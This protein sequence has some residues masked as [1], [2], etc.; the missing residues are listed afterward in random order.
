MSCPAAGDCTATGSYEVAVNSS[1]VWVADEVSGGWGSAQALPAPLATTTVATGNLS[2]ATPGN[3]AVAGDYLDAA[4]VGHASVADEVNGTWQAAQDVPGLSGI[5]RA[6][7]VVSCT[8]PGDCAASGRY[9]VIAR[10]RCTRPT[11]STA[12]GARPR[13]F[14]A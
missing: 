4:D 6:S 13:L 1:R 11:R 10:L 12:S 7:P 3:C 2:C 5:Q 8:A 9:F 14:P